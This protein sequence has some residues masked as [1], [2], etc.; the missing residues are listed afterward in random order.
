MVIFNIILLMILALIALQD[1]TTREVS[2]YL[3]FIAFIVII[4]R[5]MYLESFL[6]ILKYSG[7]NILLVMVQLALLNLYYALKHR[8]FTNIFNKFLGLG[9]VFLLICLCTSFSPLIYCF[10]LV[11][12][13]L[14]MIIIYLLITLIKRT[15]MTTTIPL[16]GGL[17]FTYMI[18]LVLELFYKGID[19]YNDLLIGDLIVGR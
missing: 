11:A 13:F 12:S 14:I 5:A 1:I 10:F 16:A 2:G 8:R 6:D 9:D 3:F 18:L 7:F 19:S 15:R 4:A 17:A